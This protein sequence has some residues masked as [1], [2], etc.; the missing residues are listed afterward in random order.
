M[1]PDWARVLQWYFEGQSL[2]GVHWGQ[3]LHLLFRLGDYR[4]PCAGLLL[5]LM[6]LSW[7]REEEETPSGVAR[8]CHYVQVPLLTSAVAANVC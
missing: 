6:H 4:G 2:W 7:A 1:G 8:R 3:A 5:F